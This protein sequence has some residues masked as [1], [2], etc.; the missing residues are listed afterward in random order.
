[1]V[2]A[3][4]LAG[5]VT[6]GACWGSRQWFQLAYT[7]DPTYAA[8]HQA[9]GDLYFKHS[10]VEDAEAEYSEAIR[11]EPSNDIH[12][13]GL[14]KVH[15][16]KGNLQRAVEEFRVALTLNPYLEE[17]KIA[18]R[19]ALASIQRSEQSEPERISL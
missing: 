5:V 13:L 6:P 16:V 15:L 8:S 1:M 10:R 4:V 7:I 17:A 19:Q 11:L 9:L 12:R 14:G 18:L 2:S 3:R